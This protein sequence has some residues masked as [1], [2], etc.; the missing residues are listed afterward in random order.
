MARRFC[1]IVGL[2]SL[3]VG[4]VWLPLG[5]GEKTAGPEVIT[6]FK[7]HTDA[8]YAVAY[9]P[10]GKFLVTASFDNTLK[11]WETATGKEVRTYG[12]ATGHTKQVISVA[13]NHDGSMIASGSTDNTLKVWDVPVSAPIRSFKASD[14]VQAVALSPD[15][16]KLAIGGKDGSLKLVTPTDFK[17]LVKFQPGHQGAVTALAFSANSQLLASVGVDRTLRYWNVLKGELLATVGAHTAGVNNLAIN[18]NNTAAYT[19]GADGF[20]KFWTLP[21]PAPSKT[22]PGHGAPIRALAM[23]NDNTAYYTGSDDRTVRHFT[24]TGAKEVRSFSGPQSGITSVATHPANLFIAAGTQDSRVFLWNNADT[25]V[26]TN[27]LAHAGAVHS[28]QVHPQGQQLMTAGADGLV[29]FWAL[30]AVLPRT[31]THPDAVLAAVASPDGKKLYTGSNDKLVRIW[32]TTKQTMEKQFAGHTGPVTAVAVSPNLQILASGSADQTIR[33]WNQQTAKEIDVLL[34]HAAPVT[35]LSINVGNTQMLSASEDGTVKLWALPLVAPKLFTHPDQITSLALS[36]DGSKVLTGGNDKVVRLWNLSSGAKEKDCAGPTLPIVSVAVSNNGATIAAASAD[37]TVTIW[38]VAGKV[39]QKLPMPAGPQALAFSADAGSVF[40]G[41]ADNSIKQIK[42]ADGKDIK[43][44][45]KHQGAVVGLA[46]SP[47]GDLLYSA[48]ADKTIQ[49]WSLPDGTPK[50]KFDHVAPISAMTLSKDGTRLA[51]VGDKVVKVWTVADGKEVGTLKLPA[52]AKGISLSPDNT[53]VIVAGADKLARIYDLAGTLLEI[54]PHDGAVNGVAFV[55]A[56]R[57]VT[58]GADKLARLWTSSLVWQRQHQGPVRQALFTPKGDQIV[59]TGDDKTIKL[60]NAADGKE[61]KSF[62]ND[63]AITHLGLSADATKI[64]TAGADKN[65]KIWTLADGKTTTTIALPATVHSLA[66]SPNGQRVAVALTDGPNN[67][68]RVHDIALGKDVQVF[69]DHLAPLKALNFLAD[70]RTLVSA[71]ADKTARLL[72]VGVLSTLVAHPAGPMFAQ[73]H[74][75]GQQ[76]VTAGADKTVKLWDLA[77]ASVLK[78]FGPVADPIKAVTFSKDFAKIGVVTGKA[79]KVWNIADGK[80]VVTL[81]H[82]V[83]VLSLSFSP[84]GARIVT[85]AA[86]KQTRLWDIAT[87][88]ELQFFAQDDTVDA[89][90]H[91]PNNVVISAAGKVTRIDIAS[92]LRQIPADAGPVHGLTIVPANTH[93]L[94]AGADKIAKLWNLT[95]GAKEREFPGATAPLQSVAISKNG[96]LLAAGGADQTVRVYQFADAKEIGAFKLAGEVRTLSFTPNNLALVASSASKTLQAVEVPFT[97]GQPLAK[98]FLKP[99]QSFTPAD[100]LA[101]FTIAADSAS[102]YSAG[103]DKAMHVWKLASPVPTRNFAYGTTVDAVAFQPNGALLA[104]AGHDGKVRLYDLV[105]NVQA[106]EITAHITKKGNQNIAEPIYSLTFS[107]DGKQLLTSSYDDSLKLWDVT[108]GNTVREFKPWTVKTFEKGHQEPVYTAAFSPDGKFIASGSSG[109]ERTIKIWNIDGSVV[110]DLANPNY[111]TAP[112]F[113]PASHPGAVTNLRFT[114]DG[115]HLI[116]VGDAPGNKGFIA[117]WDWQAG[118]MISSD[119]LQLGVFYGLALAPD[120]KSLAVTAGNRDRKFASP[121]FNAAYLLK[122]PMM[123]K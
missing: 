29:K 79:V 109:L 78:S 42:I 58:G 51:A 114:K 68:I 8:V 111:K 67:V 87:G 73:Y 34:A 50:A 110:R 94:T 86:D 122:L 18:P 96:L 24:V 47:T 84:D 119:T 56:K 99:V 12:G 22:L 97:A 85:G 31:L 15:G 10:D 33:L 82:A 14:A 53:R 23:T 63:S 61:V 19:V 98:E 121:E 27:W 17:E 102:I 48:S 43:S 71:S 11:L 89:V 4:I 77:K 25:K 21:P 91:L 93:V 112:M 106:K 60:W 66:L 52:D 103:Q 74:S 80:E 107:A 57:V 46:L 88:K 104:A 54:L 16:L 7:G 39:L 81:T 92:I 32:E 36:A 49:T 62:T 20:L 115:K 41:L 2:L 83:E 28:V 105:K 1:A 40:V 35:A 44:F 26:L 116:S 70:G 59:S 72:D 45:V 120:E 117:V 37:K 9:S 6:R 90:I 64:A 38:N 3:V 101:D 123:G 69:T 13:F 108:T 5:A 76:L 75:N 55:D 118:K 100:V 95:S 65:V 30:P 113:A